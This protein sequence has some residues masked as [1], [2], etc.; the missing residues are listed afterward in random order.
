M[1]DVCLL[2]NPLAPPRYEVIAPAAPVESFDAMVNAILAT[3]AGPVPVVA[4]PDVVAG[5]GAGRVLAVSQTPNRVEMIVLGPQ[6]MLLLARQSFVPG[7]RVLLDGAP[8][9]AYPA[10]GLYFAVP[11]PSGPHR[12]VLSYEPRGLVPGFVVALGWLGIA[13]WRTGHAAVAQPG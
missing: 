6:R 3:P 9:T 10:A 4:P 11:V 8:A 1:H 2:Q 7:W 13:W 5:V 12:V